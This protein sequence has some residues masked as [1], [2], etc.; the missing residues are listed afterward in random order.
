MTRSSA[1]RTVVVLGLLVLACGGGH[2]ASEVTQDT[3][4]DTL[5]EAAP[6]ASEVLETQPGEDQAIEV[7][8]QAVRALMDGGIH[9]LGLYVPDLARDRFQAALDLDPANREA[10]Y[11]LILADIQK[12]WQLIDMAI[13]E[14]APPAEVTQE[15]DPSAPP[16]APGLYALSPT[17]KTQLL[18]DFLEHVLGGLTDIGERQLAHLD[19]LLADETEVSIVVPAL[20]LHLATLDF[21]TLHGRWTR[22]DLYLISSGQKLITGL[23]TYLRGMDF[24]G[25]L[26]TA[27]SLNTAVGTNLGGDLFGAFPGV[28]ATSEEFLAFRVGDQDGNGVPDG[29][30]DYSRAFR[31]FKESGQDALRFRQALE[32]ETGD[33]TDRVFSVGPDSQARS[34]HVGVKGAKGDGAVV[35]WEG[36]ELSV[37]AFFDALARSAGG[38]AS[39]RLSL[40]G[41]V[42][43]ML[44]TL[45]DV[46][47]Q[48]AGLKSVS[49]LFGL[50]GAI[51][52][53]LISLDA[54]PA[55]DPQAMPKMLSGV[56]GS[57]LIP[58]GLL[59][60]DLA[61]AA[62]R[63]VPLRAVLPAITAAEPWG[64]MQRFDCP[65][66][67]AAAADATAGYA[68]VLDDPDGEYDLHAGPGNDTAPVCFRSRDSLGGVADEECLEMSESSLEAGRFQTSLAGQAVIDSAAVVK[69]DGV[70]ELAPGDEAQVEAVFRDRAC[71]TPGEVVVT[72]L[73]GSTDRTRA[74]F[75]A[76]WDG[77]ACDRPHRFPGA[78]L[79]ADPPA[80]DAATPFPDLA[81]DGWASSGPYQAWGSPSWNGLLWVDVARLRK[82]DA[83]IDPA[84][85]PCGAGMKPLDPCSANLFFT[86]LPKLIQL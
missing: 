21:L 45:V 19:L 41:H 14:L 76:C 83:S 5:G 49:G 78:T 85:P 79:L 23:F 71:D 22:T 37:A 50:T 36:S 6:E 58:T 15:T 62:S 12:S 4:A 65:I 46:V 34:T 53:V 51:A 77:L 17:R 30:D 13:A 55:D 66:F 32:A 3:L 70:L 1:K 59:E 10:V 26:L 52:D 74:A 75:V 9:A 84:N 61:T 69:G 72:W 80:A 63:P 43:P 48:S 64:W 35:L 16:A 24:Q 81:A 33:V 7:D 11:G 25:N 82:A 40:S 18:S 42:I 20:P 44:T 47:R 8:P 86:L 39:V 68:V 56:I 31:L 54:Q 2:E 38:D 29:A 73:D 67:G 57:L 27:L 28:L 60:L